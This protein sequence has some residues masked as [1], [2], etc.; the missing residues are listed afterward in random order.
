MDNNPISCAVRGR[1]KSGPYGG[2]RKRGPYNGESYSDAMGLC[3]YLLIIVLYN[4][5]SILRK[6]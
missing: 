3:E 6:S 4:I 2:R 5:I 1:D